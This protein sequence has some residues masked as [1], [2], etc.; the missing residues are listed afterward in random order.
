MFHF[1]YNSFESWGRNYIGIH[2]TENLEDNYLGSF[3][4]PTFNPTDKE[5]LEFYETRE[6]A[7]LAEIKLHNFFDVANN[8]NFANLAKAHNTG[9][10]PFTLSNEVKAKFGRK[11]GKV[12]SKKKLQSATQNCR[13]GYLKVSK[14]C[15]VTNLLTNETF[16]CRSCREV[17]RQTG[18]HLLK[19]YDLVKGRK[20]TVDEWKVTY[21]SN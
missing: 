21:K 16:E 6:E 10:F 18:M 17:S 12:K 8:P 9:S 11:G 14:A 1:V 4:D 20:E 3:R 19:V 15:L 5:I 7:E 2:S 13:K